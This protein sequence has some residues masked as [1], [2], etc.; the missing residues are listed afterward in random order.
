MNNSPESAIAAEA[1]AQRIPTE[2]IDAYCPVCGIRGAFRCY[3]PVDFACKRNT[4]VCEACGSVGRNRHVAKAILDLLP[5]APASRS[6][7]EFAQ[8][9]RG[10]VYITCIK[11]AIFEVLRSMPN[12]TAS[13]YVDGKKSGEA[14]NGF[15]CQDLQATSFEDESFDLIVTEDVLE[16]VPF[17]DRAFNEIRRILKPGGYHIG[18]IPI[19]WGRD[20]SVPRAIIEN[21]QIRHLMEPEYHGDPFRSEGILAF[22]DY[23]RDILEQFCSIIGP[24]HVLWAHGDKYYERE[25]AIYNSCV[26]V[27]QK[28]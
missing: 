20:V 14:N 4:F 23:G 9:F 25:F 7:R 16:H 18:T 11:E 27:S 19:N 21:G 10:K 6:L 28:I 2:I 13:E 26:F 3:V 24:S 15:Y 22:T 1:G 12:L 8:N 5:A 17:P